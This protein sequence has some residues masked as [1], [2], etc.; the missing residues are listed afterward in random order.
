M[1][2]RTMCIAMIL[3]FACANT[4]G[5]RSAQAQCYELI[6]GLPCCAYTIQAWP[7]IEGCEAPGGGP[8][9]G[10]P[11]NDPTTNLMQFGSSPGWTVR[12]WTACPTLPICTLTPPDCSDEECNWP[13]PNITLSCNC[14]VAPVARTD[15]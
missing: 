7:C 9:C 15:C 13:G 6:L 4:I 11:V 3:M 12:P 10:V 1:N 2:P 8:C 14:N 5:A